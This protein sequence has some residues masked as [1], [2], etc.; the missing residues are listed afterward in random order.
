MPRLDFSKVHTYAAATGGISLPIGLRSGRKI[1]DFLAFV[2]TGASHCLFAKTHGETLG[3]DIE[4]GDPKKF[5]TALGPVE[6][7]GH[8]VVIEA[9]GLSVESMIYFFA[10]EHI[11]KNLLGRNGWLDRIR[12]GLV[13]YE[14]T[15]Y[16]AEYD[17]EAPGVIS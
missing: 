13:D 6:T 1:V 17:F 3:L 10:N 5:G 11:D 15:L 8:L 2:D 16:L 14:Q 12:F 7:F 4:A 9:L